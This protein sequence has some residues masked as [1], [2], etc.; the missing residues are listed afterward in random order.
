MDVGFHLFACFLEFNTMHEVRKWYGFNNTSGSIYVGVRV[1]FIFFLL[2]TGSDLTGTSLEHWSALYLLEVLIWL[3]NSSVSKYP[4]E[5]TCK[6]ITLK[7]WNCGI[8]TIFFLKSCQLTNVFGI[9]LNLWISS[10][11]PEIGIKRNRN[12]HWRLLC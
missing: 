2:L 8:N 9:I 12:V 11:M 10:K 7:C 5:N 1:T 4:P 3:R 6:P